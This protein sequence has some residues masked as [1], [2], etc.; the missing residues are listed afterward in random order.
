MGGVSLEEQP[1]KRDRYERIHLLGRGGVGQVYLAKDRDTGEYIALKRL[2]GASPDGVLRL[3]REFRSLA[4]VRHPNLVKLY[5]LGQDDAGWFLAMEYVEGSDL[6]HLLPEMPTFTVGGQHSSA[7]PS[8]GDPYEHIIPLFYQIACGVSALHHAGILHRDLKPSNVVAGEARVVVLDFGLARAL[9]ASD[10]HLTE[11]G[12]IYGTPAYMAPEQACG[13]ALSE[14]SDWYAF[15]AMLYEAL[16]GSLPIDGDHPLALIKCK[17]EREPP[18]PHALV[19]GVPLE[20]SRLCSALLIRDPDKRPNGADVLAGLAPKQTRISF[21]SLLSEE[22]Q[23]RSPGQTSPRIFGRKRELMQLTAALQQAESGRP[24]LL[25]IQGVSGA[26]KSALVEHF[27]DA[28]E[29]R[30]RPRGMPGV[31]VLRSRCYEREAMPFKALDSVMDALMRDLSRMTDVEVGH[32]LPTDVAALAQLF[33]VLERIK[34]VQQL[35]PGSRLS[36][37]AMNSRPRAEAAFKDLFQRLASRRPV[38]LWIDDL[39]WGDLDSANILDKWLGQLSGLGILV[40]FSYRSDE[41][42]TSPCLRHLLQTRHA[43]AELHTVQLAAL[44]P[45]AVRAMCHE[46]LG[47]P[48]H[49]QSEIVEHLVREAQGSPF[50]ALQLAALA[51]AELARGGTKLRAVSLDDV[52]ERTNASLT[53][54]ARRL[55]QVL[56]VAGRPMPPPLAL[57]AAGVERAGRSVIHELGGL[58]LVRI[59][60]VAG[61]R[62]LDVYH[63]RIRHAVLS[64][65]SAQQLQALHAALLA[66]LELENGSE[67]D[68]LHAHAIGAGELGAA[69]KYG[70]A[71]AERAMAALAFARSAELFG[72]CLKLSDPAAENYA[73]LWRSLGAALVGCGRGGSAADAYLQAVKHASEQDKPPLMRLAGSHLLRSGRFEEGEDL[74]LHVLETRSLSVPRTDGGVMAAIVWERQR[75]R[76]GGLDRKLRTEHEAPHKLLEQFDLFHCLRMDFVTTDTLKAALVQARALRWALEAGEP[77]RLS[78]ALCDAASVAAIDGS[79][80]ALSRA[81]DLL[82]RATRLAANFDS[83]DVHVYLHMTRGWINWMLGRAAAAIEPFGEVARLYRLL[84]QDERGYFLRIGAMALRA[85]ALY[86]LG[87]YRQFRAEFEH[88]LS[89]ARA[90]EN[91]SALLQLAFS[92]TLA[93]DVRGV[94][95]ISL[96]RLEEQGRRMPRRRFGLLNAFYLSAVAQA[97]CATGHYEWA[98]RHLEEQWPRYLKAAVRRMA[99]VALLAHSYRINLRLHAAFAAGSCRNLDQLVAADLKALKKLQLPAS[100][101]SVSRYRARIALLQGNRASGIDQLRQSADEYERLGYLGDAARARYALGLFIGGEQGLE[102][103]TNSESYLRSE[104]VANPLGFVKTMYPEAFPR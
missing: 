50:V 86:Q 97:G 103:C 4:D 104:Q 20:L 10:P 84:P 9:N 1:R 40:L 53:A 46:A 69:L 79:R 73:A 16:T 45:D 76:W 93:D 28:V 67:P 80:Q 89:E 8:N 72:E 30:N 22:P 37:D 54:E 49:E 51:S 15:G 5:D 95:G 92:E 96:A 60:N 24:V 29:T 81:N 100:A 7:C 43:A 71:A 21:S 90:T 77:T 39:Q 35:V 52:L 98:L 11:E 66:V 33:P 14:A 18:E 13:N 26:G 63:D 75:V 61:E 94:P 57:R 85:A 56:S 59:R 47:S 27:L 31:L 99:H 2:L 70:L 12:A 65:L 32:L 101:P 102:L 41:I 55:V 68:W 38:V 82:E 74:L 6:T 62:R 78:L 17:L 25:H 64:Q 87:S 3:K 36:P 91:Q 83:P 42:N 19:P 44:P 23:H 88:A 58:K 34:A 48:G